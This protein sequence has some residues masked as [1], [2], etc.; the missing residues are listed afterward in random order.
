MRRSEVFLIVWLAGGIAVASLAAQ[1]PTTRTTA[2]GAVALTLPEGWATYE[3]D[4]YLLAAHNAPRNVYLSVRT[5]PK[6]DFVDA[7]VEE[8]ARSY[9]E[10]VREGLN[11]GQVG[12]YLPSRVGEWPAVVVEVRGS[13]ERARWIYHYVVIE[14]DE[15]YH[16]L[17]FTMRPS[18]EKTGHVAIG[19][20]LTSF[21]ELDPNE[22]A[23]RPPATRPGR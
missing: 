16:V 4:G 10:Q 1:G 8:H 3:Y 23:D 15:N 11:D 18:G 19:S 6:A 17:A 21:K 7:T 12:E 2:D 13:R 9:A 14:T 22:V 20:I 5:D